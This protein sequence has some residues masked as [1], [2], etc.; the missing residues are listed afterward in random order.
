MENERKRVLRPLDPL[1]FSRDHTVVKMSMPCPHT[2]ITGCQHSRLFSAARGHA[3]VRV[4]S[5]AT[6]LK[7]PAAR[8]G[9]SLRAAGWESSTAARRGL[10]NRPVPGMP[11]GSVVKN[12]L[13]MRSKS[14]AWT[15]P[16]VSCTATRINVV[17]VTLPPNERPRP[18]GDR[19]HGRESV[20]PKRFEGR[21]ASACLRREPSRSTRTSHRSR[22]FWRLEAGEGVASMTS[23]NGAGS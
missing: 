8:V 4:P 5:R 10:D 3:A 2:C 20:T 12:A 17:I 7:R 23:E 13:N 15:P 14:L 21:S 9:R 1:G 16:P 19:R 18:A 11:P 6:R 22:S